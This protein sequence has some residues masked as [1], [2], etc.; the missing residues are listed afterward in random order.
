MQTDSQLEFLDQLFRIIPETSV[1][2]YSYLNLIEL[3]LTPI[4]ACLR[5]LDAS[6]QPGDSERIRGIWRRMRRYFELRGKYNEGIE[7]AV[8]FR[9]AAQRLANRVDAA[10]IRLK[11][12]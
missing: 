11:D 8:I 4:A 12:E 9:R 3:H 10:W 7:A 2:D 6:D 1:S 5:A